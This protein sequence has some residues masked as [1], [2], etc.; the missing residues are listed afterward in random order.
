M[1]VKFEQLVSAEWLLSDRRRQRE[2]HTHSVA[3]LVIDDQTVVGAPL[4][5][6]PSV[7]VI[8]HLPDS[9]QIFD[10]GSDALLPLDGREARILEAPESSKPRGALGTGGVGV[11]EE[12][13]A[14][15]KGAKVSLP[16]GASR[17]GPHG[18]LQAE[19]G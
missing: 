10:R 8:D 7:A 18:K 1:P 3:R 12:E 11:V 17:E 15:A 2:M 4:R 6:V 13:R 16:V 19:E 14:E 5:R 9:R